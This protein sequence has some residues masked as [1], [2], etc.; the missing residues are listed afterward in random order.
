MKEIS[1]ETIDK[2]IAHSCMIQSEIKLIGEG[3]I[4]SKY[5]E[6]RIQNILKRAQD[7]NNLLC[8]L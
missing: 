6:D 2:I 8:E 3:Q 5:K 7:I 1:K 4:V